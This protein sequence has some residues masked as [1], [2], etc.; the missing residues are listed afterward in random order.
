MNI[1]DIKPGDFVKVNSYTDFMM[2]G[3]TK[4]LIGQHVKVIKITKSGMVLVEDVSEAQYSIAPRNVNKVDDADTGYYLR[5]DDKIYKFRY[6]YIELSKSKS[7]VVKDK[8]ASGEFYT[9]PKWS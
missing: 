3:D 6:D 2:C 1:Q 9:E 7:A 8:L 5:S 4:H